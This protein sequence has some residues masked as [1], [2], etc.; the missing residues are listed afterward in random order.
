MPGPARPPNERDVVTF[1]NGSPVYLG[2]LVSTGA[3]VNNATTA[4]PFNGTPLGAVAAPV[5]GLSVAPGNFTNTLAGKTLLLQATA[6][7][8]I[9]PSTSASMAIVPN[10]SAIIALQSVVPPALGTVPGVSL[11][12]GERVTLI[13]LPT[14]AWLQWLPVSGS[15]NCHVWELR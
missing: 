6:A 10:S 5:P 4:T 7:G 2:S 1:L 14:E 11:S 13:L 8:L 15:A 9:L 3:A 12:A